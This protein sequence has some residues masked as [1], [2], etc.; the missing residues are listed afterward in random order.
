MP[1]RKVVVRIRIT[2]PQENQRKTM[3]PTMTGTMETTPR[4][5]HLT[6]MT[7]TPDD[8]DESGDDSDETVVGESDAGY[9]TGQSK[10]STVN[11]RQRKR[12]T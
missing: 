7:M 12:N 3:I 10:Y 8:S 6:V 1:V 11:S 2:D 4:M 5:D 9:T